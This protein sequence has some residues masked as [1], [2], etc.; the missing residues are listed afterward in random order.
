VDQYDRP[1]ATLD[2]NVLLSYK[3]VMSGAPDCMPKD[4]A[5]AQALDVLLTLNRQ[6]LIRLMVSTM[7]MIENRRGDEELDLVALTEWLVS[8]GLDRSDVLTHPE[9]MAFSVPEAPGVATYGPHL[10]MEFSHAVHAIL[11]EGKVEPGARNINFRWYD[12][13]DQECE[14]RGIVAFDREALVALDFLRMNRGWDPPPRQPI[15]GLLAPEKRSALQAA[16]NAMRRTWINAACDVEHVIIH[17]AHVQRTLVPHHAVFVTS[18]RNFT[19]QGKWD[20]LKA[21]GFPGHIMAPAEAL[22][23]FRSLPATRVAGAGESDQHVDGQ[24]A[25]S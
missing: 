15:L 9:S 18:D 21:L 2:Y 25:A 20:K 5:D 11:F 19:R 3:K 10:E 8:L 4:E 1:L 12:Y 17:V 7:A 16:L 14:R 24:P 23:Y 13:R 22:A 6:G